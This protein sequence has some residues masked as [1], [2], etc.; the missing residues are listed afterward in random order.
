MPIIEVNHVTKEFQLGTIQRLKSTALNQ[1]RRL[2]GRP[3]EERAPFKALDDVNF[4]I[5]Q[6]EVLGIIA[7]NGADIS[8]ML[9]LLA[10]ISKPSSGS[11]TVKGKV[12]PLIEVDA[13]LVG[14]L[15]G[16]ENIYLS[17]TILGILKAEIKRKF[18]DIHRA[19]DLNPDS[20][21]WRAEPCRIGTQTLRG[22]MNL[23]R[24]HIISN[25]YGLPRRHCI[26]SSLSETQCQSYTNTS[27]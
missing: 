9:R 19:P 1:W 14:D 21:T 10:S 27:V 6:G 20:R 15:T 7:H 18:D 2:T 3:I 24:R 13:G 16:R 17:G 23:L 25:A 5:E 8:T 22:W 11:I 12:A 26:Q 4:S